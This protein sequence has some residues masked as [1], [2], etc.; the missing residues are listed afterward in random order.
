MEW[1]PPYDWRRGKRPKEM[2][3]REAVTAITDQLGD[4]SP[5]VIPV[6]ASAGRVYGVDEFLLPA[7]MQRLDKAHGVAFLRC[8]RA[9][10]DAGKIRKVFNQMLEAGKAAAQI[11][12]KGMGPAS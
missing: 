5:V 3:I 6:C 12:W 4:L 8:L 7:V 11:T 10:K 2:N 1:S 9:E